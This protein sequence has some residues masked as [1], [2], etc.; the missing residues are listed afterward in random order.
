M[1]FQLAP[2]DE[3]MAQLVGLDLAGFRKEGHNR[4]NFQFPPKILTDSR[5]GAWD[6]PETIGTEP[7]VNYRGTAARAFTLTYT[8]IVETI[9]HRDIAINALPV[10]VLRGGPWSIL[11]VRQEINKIRGYFTN[12]TRGGPWRKPLMVYFKHP[13]ITG[14]EYWSCRIRNVEVKH[15]ENLVGRPGYV[16]PLRSDVTVDMRLWSAI[17]FA[18]GHPENNV[19]IVDGLKPQP[20]FV[21]L[22]Y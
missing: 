12:A 2:I 14:P 1:A 9:E 8:Y 10:P 13:Y 4:I 15:S 16:Y 22:W 17:E 18:N 11:R 6:E 20:A 19:Q 7:I 3:S 21:D 5:Q